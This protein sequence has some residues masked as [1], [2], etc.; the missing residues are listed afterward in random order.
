MEVVQ[1]CVI[2]RIRGGAENKRGAAEDAV[3]LGRSLSSCKR[4]RLTY[5]DYVLEH[6]ILKARVVDG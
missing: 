1:F 2:G 6:Q 4:V 3:V 5:E